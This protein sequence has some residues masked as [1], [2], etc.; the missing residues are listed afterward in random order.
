MPAL[1][2]VSA[3]Y[4]MYQQK[5]RRPLFS[6]RSRMSF[7]SILCQLLP[8]QSWR[9]HF[10]TSPIQELTSLNLAQLLRADHEIR[11]FQLVLLTVDW[12]IK[13]MCVNP[14]HLQPSPHFASGQI[15]YFWPL[16]DYLGVTGTW[17]HQYEKAGHNGSQICR[18]IIPDQ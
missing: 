9:C 10:L 17:D 2:R 1:S 6:N 18:S 5:G 16:C 14:S 7:L 12:T 11:P 3:G 15:P 4:H 13:S 8:P